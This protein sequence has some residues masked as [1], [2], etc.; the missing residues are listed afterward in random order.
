VNDMS[1]NLIIPISR[2]P[3]NLLELQESIASE[4]FS[5]NATA[6]TIWYK[7]IKSNTHDLLDGFIEIQGDVAERSC[8]L[9][10]SFV[11]E[12]VREYNELDLA[13][14]AAISAK[15]RGDFLMLVAYGLKKFGAR[16]LY[17][18]SHFLGEADTRD[19]V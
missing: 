19:L 18:D 16:I 2:I 14:S 9:S 1:N 15:G 5:A 13:Y 17:D 8:L 10:F 6:P 11:E 4:F 12:S 3:A 7:T